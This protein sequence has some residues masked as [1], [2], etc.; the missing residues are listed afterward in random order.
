MNPLD[1][2][3][4]GATM[5]AIYR[6]NMGPKGKFLLQFSEAIDFGAASAVAAVR[7]GSQFVT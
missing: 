2:M 3:L 5:G 1:H 6:F 4:A 7:S